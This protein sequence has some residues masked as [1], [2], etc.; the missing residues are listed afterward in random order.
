MVWPGVKTGSA[1][2]RPCGPSALHGPSQRSAEYLQEKHI[3]RE[4]ERG[5]GPYLTPLSHALYLCV[6]VG[7]SSGECKTARLNFAFELISKFASLA[8][9]S[10][11]GC[12]GVE[13]QL[14]FLCLLANFSLSPGP[15]C[16]WV[17][18]RLRVCVLCV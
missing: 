10:V 13:D 4:R 7:R 8:V 3:P 12:R 18:E 11:F 5:T 16:V 2:E 15:V 1:V 9:V 17:F 14:A 6:P